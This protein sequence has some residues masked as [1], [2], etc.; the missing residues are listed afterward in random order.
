MDLN[1]ADSYVQFSVTA[2]NVKIYICYDSSCPL[3][4]HF[5]PRVLQT[6]IP[7]LAF[8]KRGK[9]ERETSHHNRRNI[10]K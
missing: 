2:F 7:N 6:S 8:L 5:L 3:F 10:I 1:M 4:F 9:K